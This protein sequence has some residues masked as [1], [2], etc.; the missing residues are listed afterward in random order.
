MKQ[1]TAKQ[2]HEKPSEVYRAATKEP[3]EL[4]HRNHGEMV[5]LTKDD[6]KDL[7]SMAVDH[8]GNG[9]DPLGI[10]LMLPLLEKVSEG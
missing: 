2:L 9:Y 1:F 6:F 10:G 8:I 5:I 4:L 3:V 7:A